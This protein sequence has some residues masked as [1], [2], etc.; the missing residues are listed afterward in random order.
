MEAALNLLDMDAAVEHFLHTHRQGI[1]SLHRMY[2]QDNHALSLSAL[3]EQLKNDL[4]NGCIT[5][6][7]K[8][9]SIQDIDGYLFYIANS[10]CKK[11]GKVSQR[12]QT[13]YICPGCL[14]LG[15]ASLVSTFEKI[16]FKCDECWSQAKLVHEPERAAFY[17]TFAVHHKLGYRCPDCDRFIPH[18]A[19]NTEM[20]S[21]PYF[22]CC[23]VGEYGVLARMYHATSKSNPERLVLDATDEDGQS[24]KNSLVS[25]EP[26]VL[27]SLE[28]REDLEN[29]VSL[30]KDIIFS[31]NSHVA[32]TSNDYTIKHKQLVYQAF[33]ALL[34]QF[35]QEM[36]SYLLE[37]SRSGGFQHKI[38]QEYVKL[39]EA[40]LPFFIKKG[41][42]RYRVDSLLS[43]YLCVFNGI[44]TFD[45]KITDNLDVK[46]ETKEFYI[47]GRK[48][49]CAR[50]YY[51][52]KLLNIVHRETKES[53]LHLVKDYTFSRIRL[54]DV[55]PQT[56]VIVTHLRIP[57]HYQ[58]G[59]MVYVNR[60]RKKIV[61][62]ALVV[63]QKS[64]N[65]S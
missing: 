17:K 18:P 38:F 20:V 55:E 47:G 19:E 48:A 54:H 27:L 3:I 61:D 4:K 28:D 11:F 36:V 39:L 2:I 63:L 24:W 29:K 35:P 44:S 53:L 15:T 50:P 40:S 46:N 64:E 21:C 23:F 37:G 22:D 10:V 8:H 30:L 33:D 43:E 60:V 26:D 62:R 52:G 45:S 59:G 65:A 42:K 56:P 9:N 6:Y 58:M 5:Y 49:S 14:F 1:I 32:Y 12:K 51:I 16:Y 13:E 25:S 7:N 31:Q 41:N 34:K 57:P